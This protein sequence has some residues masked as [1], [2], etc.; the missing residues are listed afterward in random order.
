M[1]PQPRERIQ[2]AKVAPGL[3]CGDKLSGRAV[4]PGREA[5]DLTGPNRA[6]YARAI[7][8]AGCPPQRR[9][10]RTSESQVPT[11]RFPAGQKTLIPC[12]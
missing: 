9:T 2:A 5:A 10:I 4:V 6:T 11:S 8:A 1:T 3:E 7:N 12:R